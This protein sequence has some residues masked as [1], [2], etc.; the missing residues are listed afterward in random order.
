MIKKTD[1]QNLNIFFLTKCPD[2][3][4]QTAHTD[5][6]KNGPFTPKPK[7]HLS[8]TDRSR[9]NRN[10]IYPELTGHARK[11]IL[12][13]SGTDWSRPKPKVHLSGTDRLRQKPKVHLSGTDRLR[14]NPKFTDKGASYKHWELKFNI[15]RTARRWIFIIPLWK[16]FNLRSKLK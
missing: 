11:P 2:T 4:R 16:N 9:A 10:C 3:Y 7:M 8:G 14:Q 15:F 6:K 13:L 5:P 12:H 1:F